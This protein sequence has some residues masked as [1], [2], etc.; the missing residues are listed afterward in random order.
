[1]GGVVAGW[2]IDRLPQL[3]RC[4][5]AGHA[6]EAE[7]TSIRGGAVSVHVRPA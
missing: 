7:V 1:L 3:L 5:Q 6:F 4:L 2:I